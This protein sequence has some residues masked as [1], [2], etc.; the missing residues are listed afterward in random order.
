M[1]L[2][3]APIP[4]SPR[5]APAIRHDRPVEALDEPRGDDADHALVPALVGQ[6]VAAPPLLGLRPLRDLGQRLAQDP[7]LDALPLAVQLL[8]LMGQ[9]SGLVGVLGEEKL[10][11]RTRPAETPRRVDARRQPE[12]DRSLVDAGRIDSGG[13]H[14]RPEPH[15]LR[16]RECAE[17]GERER[18]VLV[19]ER[20]DVGDR[21]ERDQVEM[22]RE[23]LVTR[24][25]QRLAELV[26]DAGAAELRET[27]TRRD[28]SRRPGSRAASRPAGGGR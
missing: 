15:L 24:A 11:R 27:D 7:V 13:L 12:P 25:E 6:D 3:S 21:R 4:S 28:A 20:D 9:L 26:D 17:A 23:R 16:A 8:E 18:P 5:P 14:Q 10:E 2:S 22:P 1:R 19:H